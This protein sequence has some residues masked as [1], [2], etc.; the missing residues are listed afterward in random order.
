MQQFLQ[1]I[2]WRLFTAQRVSGFHTPIIRSST[3][4]VAASGFYRWSVV[5]AVPL[6]VVGPTGPT[7][8]TPLVLHFSQPIQT[9]EGTFLANSTNSARLLTRLKIQMFHIHYRP[10]QPFQQ[11]KAFLF[12][13]GG[14]VGG[15]IFCTSC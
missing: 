15:R 14:G 9:R 8:K 13:G 3:T 5:V 6:V 12:G 10:W 7:D 11:R 4:A 1:F 2:T